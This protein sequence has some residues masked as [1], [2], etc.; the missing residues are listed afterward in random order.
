MIT[1][2]KLNHTIPSFIVKV[3]RIAK[4]LNGQDVEIVDREYQVSL[5]YQHKIVT[6]RETQLTHEQSILTQ[7]EALM[8]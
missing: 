3:T 5:D 8:E 7:M 2:T 4:D 6:E 1:V